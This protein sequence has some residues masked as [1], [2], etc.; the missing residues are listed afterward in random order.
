MEIHYIVSEAKNP[1]VKAPDLVSAE[2]VPRSSPGK[3]MR[4]ELSVREDGNP[5]CD[6][7]LELALVPRQT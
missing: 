2:A 1:K 5:S 3:P 6:C 4:L 7:K